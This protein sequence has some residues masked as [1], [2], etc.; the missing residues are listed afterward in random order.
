MQ[1]YGGQQIMKLNAQHYSSTFGFY[2]EQTNVRITDIAERFFKNNQI[3]ISYTEYKALDLLVSNNGIC[4][5]DLANLIFK[6]KSFA[7]RIAES[8]EQ[9][10]MIER[11]FEEKNKR[12]V[13]KLYVTDKG[14]TIVKHLF[15][16]IKHIVEIA[17][18]E[19]GPVEL[20]KLKRTLQQIQVSLEKM[21]NTKI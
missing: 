1:L 20:E 3:E 4:Q 9:K 14:K 6:D 2:I 17:L 7:S 12:L 15:S 11:R 18:D 5:Q 13:K 8:L 16:K 19:M 21:V 10:G